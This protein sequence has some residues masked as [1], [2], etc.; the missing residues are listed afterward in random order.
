MSKKSR[1]SRYFRQQYGKRDQVLLKSGSQH[2]YHMH[3]SLLSQ[4]SWENSLLLTCQI[5]GLLVYTLA[6]DEK[7][8]VLKRDNLTIPIQMHIS[9]KHKKFSEFFATFLKYRLIFKH[10]L[11]KDKLQRFCIF[12]VTVSENVAR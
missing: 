11:K 12:E 5:L 3:W 8:A 10:F 6:A 1:F 4:L 2:L 9:Q 7:C